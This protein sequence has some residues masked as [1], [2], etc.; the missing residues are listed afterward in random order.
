[1]I[2]RSVGARMDLAEL[3]TQLVEQPENGSVE[4]PVGNQ[5]ITFKNVPKSRKVKTNLPP[6]GR[7]GRRSR[8]G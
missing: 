4:T 5:K 3:Q 8:N 1:M 6:R 7:S 2:L